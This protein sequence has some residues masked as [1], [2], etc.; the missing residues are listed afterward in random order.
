MAVAREKAGIWPR[1]FAK[2]SEEGFVGLEMLRRQKSLHT[3]PVSSSAD[4]TKI[5][6]LRILLPQQACGKKGH[7]SRSP[8]QHCR[9]DH[10]KSVLHKILLRGE[11]HMFLATVLTIRFGWVWLAFASCGCRT[12]KREFCR[13]CL[14]T[15]VR[16]DSQLG[17]ARGKNWNLSSM[18]HACLTKEAERD[19]DLFAYK[20]NKMAA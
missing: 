7:F 3:N 9:V 11:K 17:V 19:W 14:A 18:W 10:T 20:T 6:A 13:A 1:I 16:R 5:V 2:R 8:R 12:G 15:E 4:R